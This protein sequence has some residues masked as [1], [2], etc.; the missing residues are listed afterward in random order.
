M[1]VHGKEL[2]ME[3]EKK[4]LKKP[5]RNYSWAVFVIVIIVA[6]ALL[7]TV[8]QPRS[9]FFR[10]NDVYIFI[11]AS[12]IGGFLGYAVVY[13]IG[14][15]IFGKLSGFRLASMNILLIRL[16][17]IEGKLQFEFC[18]P[19]G[20]GGAIFMVPNKQYERCHPF[21]YHFGG[22]IFTILVMVVSSIVC[23]FVDPTKKLGYIALCLA[24]VGVLVLI[25]NML[26]FWT[27]GVND[28]FAIR[29]LINKENRKAYFDNALQQEALLTGHHELKDEYVY[30]HYDNTFQAASLIY[31][32]YYYIDHDQEKEARKIIDLM[33][34]NKGYLLHEQALFAEN[35]KLY[36]YLLEHNDEESYDYYYSLERENRNFA[37]STSSLDN[38]KVGLL[39]AGKVEKSYDL[40]THLIKA[41][42][43]A[44]DSYYF[45][46][47]DKEIAL[48]DKSIKLI[49]EKYPDWKNQ[50]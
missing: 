19:D 14:K 29:L 40:F 9:E 32:Y 31:R 47:R 12:I 1:S 46:R 8:L 33:L 45:S 38:I 37:I 22:T 43:K 36:Y 3:E 20:L 16:T 17:R 5:Y 41:E 15:F 50:E 34:E 23:L 42:K 44:E 18:L 39:I 48:C 25:V 27:D 30:D 10:G 13:S 4:V 11:F 35:M 28:G 26:P 24:C 7:Q 6:F 49:L 21:L 2:N